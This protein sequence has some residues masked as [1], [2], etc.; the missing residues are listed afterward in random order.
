MEVL[1]PALKKALLDPRNTAELEKVIRPGKW[2]HPRKLYLWPDGTLKL[3]ED[4]W[5]TRER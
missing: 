4:A 2:G 5:D 3:S 1:G